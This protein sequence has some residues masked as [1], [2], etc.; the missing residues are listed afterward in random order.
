MRGNTAAR[1]A[2]PGLSALLLSSHGRRI[3]TLRRRRPLRPRPLP[4][5]LA[6]LYPT[7]PRFSQAA[8]RLLLSR[9]LHC[10]VLLG[11]GQLPRGQRAVSPRLTTCPSV[12]DPS[13]LRYFSYFT[14]LS[15]IG[16]CAY[17]WAAGVQTFA[18]ARWD[19][20][21][22]RHWPRSLQFLHLWLSSTAITFRAFAPSVRA[23]QPC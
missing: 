2:Q 1:F 5:N 17:F 6:S 18:Y 4:R 12:S 10:Q 16:L 9:V 19:K 14:H 11:L 23:L 13:A 8:L 3:L 15:Q 21:P 22:L 7:P 20:Y